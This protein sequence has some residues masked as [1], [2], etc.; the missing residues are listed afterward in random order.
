MLAATLLERPVA[1]FR[2]S[3]RRNIIWLY[4][5]HVTNKSTDKASH[6]VC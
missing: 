3:Q 2:K 6:A 1:S 5:A 4:L